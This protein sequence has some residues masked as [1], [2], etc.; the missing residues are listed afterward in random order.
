MGKKWVPL[1][2]N[3]EVMNEYCAKLG[4]NPS[5]HA[6]HDVFGLDEELLAMVPKPVHAV[7]L[8]YPI[9]PETEA[10]AKQEDEQQAAQPQPKSELYY[11][12]QTVSNA[13][14]TMA[15]LHAV[16][17][18]MDECKPAEGSF[19]DQFFKA[20]QSLNPEERAKFIEDP[21]SDG[22]NIE[23]AHQSAA[24][25]GQSAA[26]SENE[27][28]MLHFVTFIHKDGHLWQLDGRRRAPVCHGPTTQDK[29]L[30]SSAQIVKQFAEKSQSI[31]FNV[32]ALGPAAE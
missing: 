3:P 13:C 28:V 2:S 27:E 9:T 10:A 11:S 5:K 24:A 31:S 30:E 18:N 15:I 7:I 16:G 32:V 4:L 14:G 17:N 19:L 23:S 26:P 21:P 22:P 20:T 25:S 6:F 1:E 29:L 12:K 8:C